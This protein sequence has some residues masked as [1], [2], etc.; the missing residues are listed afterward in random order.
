MMLK[1]V[2]ALL[3]LLLAG[4]FPMNV[5]AETPRTETAIFAGGCFWCMHAEYEKL[6]GISSVLSGY[7]GGEMANPTY[8]Q[9]SSGATGHVEAVKIVFDPAK[10]GYAK[11]LDVFWSN[12]DPTDP[13]GQFCDRGSQYTA[14]IFY[15]DGAQK[16]EAEKSIKDVEEKLNVRVEAFLRP[17][18]PFYA[19]EDYHQSYHRKN[20]ARYK[21]YKAGCGRDRKLEKIWGEK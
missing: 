6:P 16:A 9:V 17:A 2:Y 1:R 13:E 18:K 3:F 14:G 15:L 10:T 20:E 21:M 5:N 8:E 4:V 12:I 19:A 7:T 11:L